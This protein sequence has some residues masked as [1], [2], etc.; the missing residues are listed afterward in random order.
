MEIEVNKNYLQLDIINNFKFSKSNNITMVLF[1][2]ILKEGFQGNL[3]LKF[4]LNDYLNL[5]NKDIRNVISNFKNNQFSLLNTGK[6]IKAWEINEDYKGSII[7]L[8]INPSFIDFLRPPYNENE[9]LKKKLFYSQI[10]FN[11][12][13]KNSNVIQNDR[14]LL[15]SS[16]SK[17]AEHSNMFKNKT[18]KFIID[19]IPLTKNE[20]NKLEKGELLTIGNN[21]LFGLKTI[22]GSNKYNYYINLD[23]NQIPIH[24]NSK[25]LKLKFDTK[26]YV[27]NFEQL[28]T[29]DSS[30]NI[31]ILKSIKEKIKN[32]ELKNDSLLNIGL[33]IMSGSNTA[34]IGY[35]GTGKTKTTMMALNVLKNQGKKITKLAFTNKASMNIGGETFHSF[36]NIPKD[37]FDYNL[38]NNKIN[39]RR[40]QYLK[41]LITNTDI[42]VIE[43]I[44]MVSS[45]MLQLFL[46]FIM[47][48]SKL[49]RHQFIVMGD[50]TQLPPVAN[51]TMIEKYGNKAIRSCLEDSELMDIFNF[52]WYKLTYNFRATD[53]E[54]KE[55]QEVARKGYDKCKSKFNTFMNKARWEN[56]QNLNPLETLCIVG[57]NKTAIKL[58]K[59]MQ[60]NNQNN[61]YTLF[62]I[63]KK[64]NKI[65]FQLKVGDRVIISQSL[66]HKDYSTFN[67][68][69]N[70]KYRKGDSVI[71]VNT[72]GQFLGLSNDNY[73]LFRVEVGNKSKYITFKEP[74]K[75]KNY[76]IVSD[77]NNNEFYDLEYVWPVNLGYAI[78]THKVQC[79]TFSYHQYKNIYIDYNDMFL[80]NHF[81]TALTRLTKFKQLIFPL[82]DKNN[83]FENTF[84][85]NISE[86]TIKFYKWLKQ[87][88][89]Y[90][91]K[92]FLQL[93][94][95]MKNTIQKVVNINNFSKYINKKETFIPLKI[96]NM[97]NYLFNRYKGISVSSNGQISINNKITIDSF[98]NFVKKNYD[99]LLTN[100]DFSELS[101]LFTIL[102]KGKNLTSV[103]KIDIEKAVNNFNNV[104][105]KTKF[106][107]MKLNDERKLNDDFFINFNENIFINFI[108]N[109]YLDLMNYYNYLKGFMNR[110]IIRN[111]IESYNNNI[112][113]QEIILHYAADLE[114]GFNDLL[115]PITNKIKN[116]FE[117]NIFNSYF[118]LK[119]SKR[120]YK[121]ALNI[122]EK[123]YVFKDNE[124][125]EG[126][127]IKLFFFGSEKDWSIN[128]F[129]KDNLNKLF[130]SFRTARLMKNEKR[131][132]KL[133][134]G[135][136]NEILNPEKDEVRCLSYE[137]EKISRTSIVKI[138]EIYVNKFIKYEYFNSPLYN[139]MKNVIQS[140]ESQILKL[141]N[142][143]FYN[144]I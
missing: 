11:E 14:E 94:K 72:F 40:K 110:N 30:K 70:I 1:F 5:Q 28:F 17:F 29:K 79:E 130:K 126:S 100:D 77:N 49:S 105:N 106:Y 122:I 64:G 89:D 125:I 116:L 117:N 34:V 123:D 118:W 127:F 37:E 87:K 22:V 46:S 60:N 108:N 41:D 141:N 111:V 62:N 115:I 2:T 136:I 65:P 101:I 8:K 7:S 4:N 133:F 120:D 74:I 82:K 26:R 19:R 131:G 50:M 91:H 103:N 55:F 76:N 67:S 109:G 66:H 144:N 134:R 48:Y 85:L 12:L 59:V 68:L 24:L 107:R 92:R 88:N 95:D 25:K 45:V 114:E 13:D 20:K 36:F 42:F 27:N 53:K 69:N 80:E 31:K 129:F 83:M 138:G 143:L 140:F 124:T 78:T 97:K 6:K 56:I 10:S 54:L 44:G 61:S 71:P 119:Q 121:N 51:K 132:L 63:T 112:N 75:Y 102:H 15:I 57:T 113:N 81:Y 142:E 16:Y 23:E 90:T 18:S 84:S 128:K 38:I 98:N 47:N 43:E 96:N 35:A 93:Y 86:E 3:D 135:K 137:L 39:D 32:N 139:M 99:N 73:P 58:N 52:Q 33:D 104:L 9:T 21:T